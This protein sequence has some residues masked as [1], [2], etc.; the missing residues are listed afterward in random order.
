MTVAVALDL[1]VAEPSLAKPSNEFLIVGSYE[2]QCVLVGHDRR[3]FLVQSTEHLCVLRAGDQHPQPAAEP[4]QT[5][6]EQAFPD[7]GELS[8]CFE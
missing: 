1:L 8:V 7:Q 3:G 5:L 6:L 4:I 2:N